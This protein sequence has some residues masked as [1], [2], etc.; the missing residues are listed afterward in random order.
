MSK[1]AKFHPDRC[2]KC[3][4]IVKPRDWPFCPHES[5]IPVDAARLRDPI[6]YYK[7]AAG[8]CWYP[9][10]SSD[11]A[12]KGYEQ[13]RITNMSEYNKFAKE[14]SDAGLR[15]S[16]RHVENEERVWAPIEERNR[17]DLLN[18]MQSMGAFERAYAQA[19]IDA[20]NARPKENGRSSGFHNL[21]M[22]YD[23]SN[24]NHQED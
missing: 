3:K 10:H 2:P 20:N 21:A 22:E 4:R 13:H 18:E 17:K 16:E 15:E 24:L 14:Q 6:I 8:K 7:N 23:R 9:G 19:A 1:M 12:P 5:T 11:P